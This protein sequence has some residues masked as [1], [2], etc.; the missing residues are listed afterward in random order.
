MSPVEAFLVSAGLVALAEM[1]DKTQLLALVL[2]CR[3]R[4]PWPIAAGMLAATLANHAVAGLAGTWVASLIGPDTL[5][6]VV[7]ASFLAMAGWTLVPDKLDGEEAKPGAGTGPFIATLV[8][9]FLA[10]IGD[11]TQLATVAL[12]ARF[13]PLWTV[14]LGT[15]VGMMAANLPV[16]WLAGYAG[17]RIR[18][19]WVRYAAAALFA[20]LGI[21]AFFM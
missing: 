13:S 12:A 2:A 15:T 9:F 1:G 16:V 8:C 19:D 6:W 18:L 5:R 20:A 4:R 7:G 3:F 14:V 17:Q 21:A 11:K 10:E